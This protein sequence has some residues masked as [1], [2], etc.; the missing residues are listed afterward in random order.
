LSYASVKPILNADWTPTFVRDLFVRSIADLWGFTLIG[1]F[2]FK[3]F[4]FSRRFFD[5][6]QLNHRFDVG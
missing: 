2:P 1:E 3:F 6:I 4:H 5:A